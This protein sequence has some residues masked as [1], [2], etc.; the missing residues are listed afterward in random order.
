VEI[1]EWL[2]CG[3]MRRQRVDGV[4][5]WIYCKIFWMDCLLG[6]WA[7]QERL[8]NAFFQ[9]TSLEDVWVYSLWIVF[10]IVCLLTLQRAFNMWPV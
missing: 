6:F 8:M 5:D 4:V 2:G 9:L 1:L 7:F 10:W 3:S